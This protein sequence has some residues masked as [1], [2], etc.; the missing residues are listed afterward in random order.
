MPSYTVAELAEQVSG[1]VEG[2]SGRR[3][4]GLASVSRAGFSD[5]TF[6]TAEKYRRLLEGVSPG[7]ALV[8]VDM[9]IERGEVTLIRVEDPQLALS[10]LT[11]LFFPDP[12]VDA[13]IAATAQIGRRVTLGERVAIGPHVVIGDDAAIGDG[14]RIGPLTV[15]GA[16]ARIG[17]ECR[18][19][20][21]CSVG[22]KV[23]I[24]D[25]VRLHPGVRLGTDGF[26]YAQG[27]EGVVKMPQV[28]GCILGDDVE[29]GA[30][31][32]IDRGSFG[33][34]V[35]GDRTKIDNLVQIGHNV[36]IGSDC[37]IV[38]QVGIAGSSKIGNGVI[39][40]GQVGVPDH[41]TVGDGARVG[42]QA[43]ILRSVPAGST[44]LGSPALPAATTM[45]V[46]ATLP[47]LPDIL[48]RLRS[49]E[50]LVAARETTGAEPSPDDE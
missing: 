15:I 34:T 17:L 35:V 24:G 50:R 42:A 46:F 3:I 1:T 44:Y 49:L 41:V 38:A 45:R 29:V 18:V 26:G 47:R 16:E 13:S 27:P 28:G 9:A 14:T 4:E 32:T 10:R 43:G 31:S 21:S 2:D 39:L 19:A 5:L 30:N 48:K 8:P 6:V 7:A 25:R 20:D 12:E 40:A 33:D 23:R 22:E 36:E 37:L 11:G